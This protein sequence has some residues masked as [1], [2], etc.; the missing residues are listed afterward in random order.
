MLDS[1][2]MFPMITKQALINRTKCGNGQQLLHPHRRTF[3]GGALGALIASPGRLLA[4]PGALPNNPFILLLTGVYQPVVHG[5][6]LG[7]SS[8]NLSDGTYSKTEIYPIFGV[9]GS[10]DQDKTIGDF[11]VQFNGN[12]CAYH[13][14]GGAIA[15][16]F[17]PVP[18]GA[19]P[20]FN[21]FVPFPDGMGGNY[22]EGTFELTILEA[23]GIYHAFA[24][25]HNHMV[26]RLHQLAN[27]SFDEFCF[28]NISQYQF[29]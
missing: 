11:Y 15:M 4:E 27:G 20:G 26:D 1:H 8:V 5:P 7:L 19:P 12:L 9:Q 13:L 29:P 2:P 25:G 28:C 14:P 16:Q 21:G 10:T 23:T 18:A 17:Q 6:N 22:L 3:L 24:G